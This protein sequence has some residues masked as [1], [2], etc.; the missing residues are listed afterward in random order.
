MVKRAVKSAHHVAR[1]VFAIGALLLA[2]NAAVYA[3][4][5]SMYATTP[6]A[7]E[8]AIGPRI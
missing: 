6:T 7:A 3:Q 5:Y 8:H 4:P 1:S 2:L